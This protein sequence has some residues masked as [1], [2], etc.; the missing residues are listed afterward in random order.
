MNDQSYVNYFEMLDVAEDAKPGEV[1]NAYKKHMKDLMLTIQSTELNEA[2]RDRFLLDIARLN[3]AYFILRDNERRAKYVA[4]RQRVMA[5][6]EEWRQHS[7]DGQSEELRK[8]FDAALRHFLSTYME[9]LMLQAGRDAEC[10]E[11]SNWSPG[12]ERH[13]S[14]VVR[15]FRQQ[16]YH[17]IHE[18]LPYYDVTKPEIDWNERAKAAAGLLNV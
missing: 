6:E 13:A 11:A 2:K 3:A 4:D 8:R 10:V 18:R 7:A 16:L 14:R 9:E 17:E 12:H 5:L 15:H 1:R